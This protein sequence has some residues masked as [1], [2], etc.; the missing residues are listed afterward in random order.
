MT[1][2]VIR[3]TSEDLVAQLLIKRQRLEIERVAMGMDA[4]TGHGFTFRGSHEA[5]ADSVLSMAFS[6][7]ELLDKQPVPVGVSDQA[8]DDDSI[9]ARE[10]GE[11]AIVFRCGSGVIVCDQRLDDEASV[12]L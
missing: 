8:T 9:A 11:I 4:A 2:G 5:G 1:D 3:Q 6:D 10:D 12:C 7:P